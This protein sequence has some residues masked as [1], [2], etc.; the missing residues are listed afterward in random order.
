MSTSLI[1]TSMTV[2]AYEI[3]FF[4]CNLPGMGQPL[5]ISNG[6]EY[7]S[8]DLIP[9]HTTNITGLIVYACLKY[10]NTLYECKYVELTLTDEVSLDKYIL[11][12][13][14]ATLTVTEG[15][16]KYLHMYCAL[17]SI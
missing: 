17:N 14:S 2:K 11:T 10:N 7:F 5:W 4:P 6:T 15:K 16:H 9:D 12:S 3:A 1:P 8:V 13:P